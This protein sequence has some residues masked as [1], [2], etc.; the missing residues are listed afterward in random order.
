MEKRNT[1]IILI[2]SF[3]NSFLLYR[4]CDVLYYLSKGISNS[5]YINYLSIEYKIPSII[6]WSISSKSV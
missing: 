6:P 5:Q 3:F 4:S 2:Y 1:M